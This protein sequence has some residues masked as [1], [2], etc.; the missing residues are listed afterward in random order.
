MTIS[1]VVQ[2][3]AAKITRAIVKKDSQILTFRVTI[4]Q[5]GIRKARVFTDEDLK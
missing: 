2:M 3:I 1:E 5:G 4:S